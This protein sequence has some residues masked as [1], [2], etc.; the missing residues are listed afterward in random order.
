MKKKIILP[1]LAIVSLTCVVL[2]FQHPL[3]ISPLKDQSVTVGVGFGAISYL[4]GSVCNILSRLMLDPVS[5]YTL[6]TV[7]I[8][9]IARRKMENLP[10]E[11]KPS[12]QDTY[13]A[14]RDKI[15]K[16]YSYM[17]DEAMLC[18]NKDVI[19]EL[20]K[21]RQTGR[22]CRSALIPTMLIFYLL[23]IPASFKVVHPWMSV[24]VP[25]LGTYVFILV[26]YAYSEVA[27]FTE[28][29]RGYRIKKR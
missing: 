14:R 17:I 19:N 8:E 16:A 27:T 18:Q 29:V 23:L 28:A 11:Y 2:W 7:F 13:S 9:R 24:V 4:V 6:R 25:S 21:R 15:N 1:G 10:D 26:M 3:D 12:V 5:S 22:L 20:L